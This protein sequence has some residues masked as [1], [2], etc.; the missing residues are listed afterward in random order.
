MYFARPGLVRRVTT[1][2]R[3]I[4]LTLGCVWLFVTPQ[5]GLCQ[6]A[7]QLANAPTSDHYGL[8]YRE[9]QRAILLFRQGKH[10]AAQ[11]L[12]LEA[13]TAHSELPPVDVMMARLYL[14]AGKMNE[15]QQALER[16]VVQAPDDPEA[17]V[18]WGDL[19][20]RGKQAAFAEMAYNQ[21]MRVLDRYQVNEDRRQNLRIRVLAGL[22]SLAETRE[23]YQVAVAH[24]KSWIDTQPNSALAH[25]S[26]GRVAFR[27]KK[28]DEARAAFQ[29]L[30]EI[31]PKS[32]PVE[33][34]MGRLFAESS[35]YDEAYAEMMVAVKRYPDDT[36]VLLTV[37]EWA[38]NNGLLEIAEKTVTDALAL[39]PKSVESQVLAARLA[40]YSGHDKKAETLLG[41]L[42][43]LRPNSILLADEFAR[44]LASSADPERRRAALQHAERNYRALRTKNSPLLL[45]A[46]I[47]YAWALHQNDQ[48]DKALAV[49]QSLPD[50]SSISNENGYYVASIFA[51]RQN[52]G[53]AIEMLKSLLAE[54]RNF[55]L[56]QKAQ[57]LL[58]TLD[59]K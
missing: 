41:E 40:R 49:V 56:R 39:A 43:P 35:M 20:L 7:I 51:G 3:T 54:N 12:L 24:L 46:I 33:I 18:L 13:Q 30:T 55:P 57:D 36:R 31:A 10:D 59:V 23:Q 14:S 17:Y 29:Q 2:S 32:P 26:L 50:G 38:L 44:T 37:S 52:H 19:A 4:V 27:M 47:T 25:G 5:T 58:A 1:I 8:K 15:A 9:V 48:S 21:A 45:Q 53:V 6:T 11:E 34:A 16:V 28:Y 22:A 42:M